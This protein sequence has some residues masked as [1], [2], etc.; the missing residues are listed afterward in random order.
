MVGMCVQF[1]SSRRDGQAS[2]CRQ[3]AWR[4]AWQFSPE[5]VSSVLWDLLC[6]RKNCA[7]DRSKTCWPRDRL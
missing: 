4:S 2:A 3:W 6:M 5:L 7:S 1:F